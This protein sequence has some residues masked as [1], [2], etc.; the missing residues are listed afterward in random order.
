MESSIAKVLTLTV[1][2][3]P[4]TLKLPVITTSPVIVPPDELYF[5]LAAA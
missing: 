2:V 1:T 3:V 4:S 5:V